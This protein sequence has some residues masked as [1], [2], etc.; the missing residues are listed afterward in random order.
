M[1][2]YLGME[3]ESS[4]EAVCDHSYDISC[5]VQW[6]VHGAHTSSMRTWNHMLL[7]AKRSSTRNAQDTGAAAPHVRLLTK[8]RA[9]RYAREFRSHT[10]WNAAQAGAR[11]SITGRSAHVRDVLPQ[12]VERA[13]FV[14][15]AGQQ[16]RRGVRG[17]GPV[18][19]F[20]RKQAGH[21]V[22]QP[23]R[24]GRPET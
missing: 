19:S 10:S 3:R 9:S 16:A 7:A 1:R 24:D 18:R 5:H 13:L 11:T 8:Q 14:R 2:K 21:R 6:N 4:M 22:T 15:E 20:G 17:R 23:E 12:L